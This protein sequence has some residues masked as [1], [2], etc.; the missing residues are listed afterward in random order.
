[1]KLFFR[2]PLILI[3]LVL[4]KNVRISSQNVLSGSASPIKKGVANVMKVTGCTLEEAIR[5]ASTNPARLYNLDDRGVI[6]VGK[7]ADLILFEIIDNEI[8]IKQTY[9]SGKLVYD[10][11]DNH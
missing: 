6:E 3:Q 9:A 11:S 2:I 8:D 4:L 5:M 10:S 1:M 7:R